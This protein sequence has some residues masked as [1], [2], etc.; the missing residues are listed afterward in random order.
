[1]MARRPDQWAEV[2]SGLMQKL[3]IRRADAIEDRFSLRRHVAHLVAL[4]EVEQIDRPL[5]L[6]EIAEPLHGATKAVL[7]TQVGPEKAEVIGNVLASRARM[8]AAFGVGETELI[9]T[10]MKRLAGTPELVEIAPDAAPVREVVW[11]GEEADL[12][13]LPVPFQ[14]GLDG[15][16]YISAAID[17]SRDAE[18]GLTNVG[19]RRLMLRGRHEAGVDLNAPSDLRALY[20]KV[21]ASGKRMPVAFVVGTHPLDY[22]AAMQRLPEDELGIVAKLRAAPLP[23]VKCLTSD[24]MVPADGEI[25]IEGY[26]DERGFTEKEGPYGEFLGYYGVVKDNPVLHVTAIT[27]RRKPLFQTMTIGGRYLGRTDT[28]QL[29]A[30]RSEA[31]V[32]QA[33]RSAIRE[34]LA[35][36]VSPASGGMFNVRLSIRQRVPGEARNA[37]AAAMGCLANVKHVFVVDEDIDIFSDEQMDWALAT[38]FQADRDL[39]VESGFRA[40]PLDPSLAGA[41]IGAKA[42]FD[43]TIPAEQRNS[44]HFTL[45]EPPVFTAKSSASVRDA[46]AKGPLHFGEIMSAVGSRDGREIV[47]A[48]DEIRGEGRLSRDANGRYVMS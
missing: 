36:Y 14:H 44:L 24:L 23:V 16:P 17:Y 1:M 38:R 18:T 34:P 46:L 7:F 25:V 30:I 22:V 40:L 29:N 3:A 15:A 33:L 41:R 5:G 43:L 20:A 21:A 10:L 11:Q 47:V 32:W 8:A 42:G 6:G 26:L 28:S 12:T 27:M 2:G 45:P 39:V 31:V 13:R 4:G 35:V 37:I 48:L 9:P 19:I